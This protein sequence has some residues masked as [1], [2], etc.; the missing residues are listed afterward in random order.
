M[1]L[2]SITVYFDNF[3]KMPCNSPHIVSNEYLFDRMGE[4]GVSTT[5]KMNHHG[6]WL[7]TP[8]LIN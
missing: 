8:R 1:T 2:K 7:L 4:L 3:A 6:E 5:T